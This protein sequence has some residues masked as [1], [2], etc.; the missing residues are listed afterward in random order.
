[1]LQKFVNRARR[2]L[3]VRA[4]IEG[5]AEKPRLS[6]YRSN[7][8]ISVQ[9]IDDVNGVTLASASCHGLTGTK[10]EKAT[11]VGS[12]IA[13]KL[14]AQKISTCIFDRGGYLYHGRVQALADA[15]RSAG[16]NF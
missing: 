14:L 7:T 13:E 12:Q 5:T 11:Q 15:A 10:S 9:A 1:M 8:S 2:A 6:V 3:R 4:R 16:L